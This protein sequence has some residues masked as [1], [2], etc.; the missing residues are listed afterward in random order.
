MSDLGFS[1]VR[2]PRRSLPLRLLVLAG[3]LCSGAVAFGE[4]FRDEVLADYRFQAVM[5]QRDEVV[6]GPMTPELDAPGGCDGVKNGNCGFHTAREDQPWW[7]VDLGRVRRVDQVVVWNRCDTVAARAAR[8]RLLLSEDGQTWRTVYTHDGTVF[9][10]FTDEQ[11]LAV[12]LENERTRFVRVQLPGST[13]LHL[14]EVEVFGPR[15]PGINL[16]FHRRATQ[17]SVSQWSTR[18]DTR[19][20]ATHKP[21]EI[22]TEARWAARQELLKDPLLDFEAILFTKRIPGSFNHMS[23]QY[24]GWWSR[25]GGGIY[26][27]RGYKTEHPT[28]ECITTAFTAPGSF[29]RPALSYDGKKV[30]FAWC[31]HYPGL[32]DEQNKLDKD[33]LP[34]DSF[35]HLFEMD[36]DGSNVRQITH[37]KYNDFDARY[38]P[39]GR[40]VFLSTRRGHAIQVGRESAQE[41]VRV[42]DLPE[43]YVR[44]GGGPERPCAVYTLHTVNSDG[45]NLCAIS[46]FEMFEWT[47][48]VADN[49]T[50][51]YSRWDYVDRDNM[52]YMSLWSMN[53][54]GTQA[55]ILYGNFTKAP[56]CTFEPRSIPNSDKIIFTGSGHHAQTMGS[57][58]LLDTAA[59]TEGGA[60]ITRLTPE[61]VF[62]EIEGW[63]HSYYANPWPLS[64]DL[65]L[66]AWGGEERPSQGSMR[67]P[68]GMGVYLFDRR[69]GHKELLVR[70]PKYSCMYPIPVK[71]RPKPPVLASHVD[72]NGP[73]EG[74]FLLLDVYQGLEQTGRGGIKALRLVAVPPKTHPTMNYPMLGVTRDDPGKCVLGTV[75][76]E[77]DGSAHFRAPSGVILFFQALDARGMAVQT[78]RSAT[79]VQPGQQVSCVGCHESRH[80]TPH[81][82]MALAARRAPSRITPGPPGSWPL[83][84]DTLVQP[85][86]DKHCVGCH[87]PKS[88]CAEA[89]KIDLRPG[90]AYETLVNYGKPSIRDQVM[91]G[92]RNGYSTEGRC[93]A[94]ESRLLKM[95][96]PPAEHHGVRLS[97]ADRE[98]LITWMDTYAQ[99]QGSFGEA[100]EQRLLALRERWAELLASR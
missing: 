92:Y 98:R 3:C 93:V 59:G 82:R 62:P 18:S 84:F 46:P 1:R 42:A 56:H 88:G 69:T 79:Y 65:Y 37:G 4:S 15:R 36:L 85:V 67:S 91:A 71:P 100:Q 9:H 14:D 19:F 38:L 96:M 70:D 7:Q 76:V 11:P 41:T 21:P 77:K 49:G 31:R 63:P 25:P 22:D 74:T 28:E 43:A 40:I 30:L 50:I 57:L 58:V 13:Y 44:C 86:L 61:V 34:E 12:R 16:A 35:Y 83:R 94:S 10:G 75:P 66:V 78:M 48:A 20:A 24:F 54:D 87:T 55:R 8:L 27:L 6:S 2:C 73:Q 47:P 52:P 26:L 33:N 89:H 29:L 90:K 5:R 60:P 23:D 95:F 32:K 51:L 72:W 99:W 68:N 97:K 81:S 39:D 64:E 80:Q 53:P 17:S 45:S